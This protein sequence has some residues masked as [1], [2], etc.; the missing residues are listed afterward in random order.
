LESVGLADRA[1]AFTLICAAC[2]HRTDTVPCALC[3]GDPRLQGRYR[4]ETIESD[5]GLGVV[6]GAG[7]LKQG[8]TRVQVRILSLRPEAVDL[9]RQWLPRWMESIRAARHPTIRG[10]LDAFLMGDDRAGTLGIVQLPVAW[11]TLEASEANPW[12]AGRTRAWMESLLE[13]LLLLHGA[14]TPISCGPLSRPRVATAQGGLPLVLHPVDIEQYVHDASPDLWLPPEL[15]T[16]PWVPASDLYRVASLAVCL[17]TGKSDRQ[18]H[19][20]REG[21]DWHRYLQESHDLIPLLDQWLS[22]DPSVRPQGVGAALRQ[23]RQLGRHVPA[24][25][26]HR[27]LPEPDEV[28]PGVAAVRIP[29]APDPDS[30][31]DAPAMT[32]RRATRA[33][34]RM[35][36][37]DA[38]P[39]ALPETKAAS[40]GLRWLLVAAAFAVLVA[41]VATLQMALTA[42]GILPGKPIISLQNPAAESP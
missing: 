13:G 39:T 1:D 12:S 26:V 37:V 16:G 35:T 4:L 7:D 18:L 6:Y 10:W 33:R 42:T 21:H 2:G 34:R 24:A 36:A 14:Q 27:R 9:V 30:L 40:S 31:S 23:L 19:A 17:L 28:P 22:P 5:D 25:P 32:S 3:G 29:V 11:P 38:Q 8:G 15:R 41:G 20:Q